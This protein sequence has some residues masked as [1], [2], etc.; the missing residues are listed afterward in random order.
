M[1]SHC[2]S[3]VR[4]PQPSAGGMLASMSNAAWGGK[5]KWE[6]ERGARRSRR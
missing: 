5:I 3:T 4:I 6:G 2:G 1:R